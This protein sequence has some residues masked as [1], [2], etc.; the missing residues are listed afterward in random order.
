M[1]KPAP[2]V[3]TL[4]CSSDCADC[5]SQYSL[6]ATLCTA[7]KRPRPPPC[8]LGVRARADRRD[9]PPPP[10]AEHLDLSF[11]E[12]RRCCCTP[13]H[14]S[15]PLAARGGFRGRAGVF[16]ATQVVVM[17]ETPSGFQCSTTEGRRCGWSPWGCL[18][19]RALPCSSRTSSLF[20][21]EPSPRTEPMSIEASEP[22]A[23]GQVGSVEPALDDSP[24]STEDGGGTEQAASRTAQRQRLRLSTSERGCSGRGCWLPD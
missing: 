7:A 18:P 10:G 9:L 14:P 1:V 6:A 15:G 17:M 20:G 23:G 4:S 22:V 5:P 12:V 2:G 19:L 11:A 3:Q 21:R 13:A 16:F 24:S 8:L